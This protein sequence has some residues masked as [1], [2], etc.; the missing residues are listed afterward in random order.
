MIAPWH[1]HEEME[2]LLVK[3]DGLNYDMMGRMFDAEKGGRSVREQ[4]YA[5]SGVC[6]RCGKAY[7]L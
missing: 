6:F 1:W 2:L 7:P 5:T 3:A 4:Q